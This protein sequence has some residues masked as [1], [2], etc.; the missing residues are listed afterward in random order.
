VRA[1][2]AR[3]ET[4]AMFPRMGP[5]RSDVRP[6]VRALVHRPFIV[7]YAIHPNGDDTEVDMVEIVRIVD[8]RRNLRRLF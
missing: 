4:L 2:A 3:I 8:G 7:L 1:I 5:L 6:D